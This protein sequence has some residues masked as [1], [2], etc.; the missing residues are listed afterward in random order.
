MIK[1]WFEITAA[2]PATTAE[3]VTTLLI[4]VGSPAVWEDERDDKKILR[5]YTPADPSLHKKKIELN[6]KLRKHGWIGDVILFENLDWLT[7]WKEHIRPIRISKRLIIK[8]TWKRVVKK[9]G[10]IIVEIDPGMAFG[11]G[12]HASTMMCLKAADKLA[13]GIK[14][15]SVLDVGTGSGILAITAAKL[16]AKKVVGLDRDPEALKVARKNVRLNDVNNKVR[17]TTKPLEKIRAKFFI[18]F[19]NI[20]A[21]ELIK[22]ASLLKEMIRDNGFLILSGILQN[23]IDKVEAVYR[24]L[25]FR[26]V[27]TYTQGEWAC[28]IFSYP[29]GL[30]IK[31]K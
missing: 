3:K 8:P 14:S 23:R 27:K 26:P 10:R 28:R 7:K 2:G 20:I 19:A 9:F 12:S 24:G 18:I 15:K 11:T 17:I 31:G 21:E 25:G 4:D 29:A 6:K 16:G 13:Q 1:S 5:A 22:I 30:P